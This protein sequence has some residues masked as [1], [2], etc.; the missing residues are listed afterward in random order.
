[1]LALD[2][3]MF[4][5]DEHPRTLSVVGGLYLL[6]SPPQRRRVLLALERAVEAFPRLA[7][8]AVV[9]P[10]RLVLPHW[11]DDPGFQLEDHLRERRLASPGSMR[12]LLDAVRPELAAP[13]EADRP[14]WD[15][16]LFTG[17]EDGRGAM[18][19]R[20]SHALTDG[21]GAMRLFEAL[22]AEDVA[23]ARR[24][25]HAAPATAPEPGEIQAQAIARLSSGAVAGAL[26]MLPGL[27]ASARAAVRDP[28]A[29]AG[30]V[31]SYLASVRRVLGPP[32]P[33]APTLAGR[34]FAR[35][36]A[37]LTVPLP[38][39]KQAARRLESSINDVYLA[40]IAGALRRYQLAVGAEPEDVPLAV[41]VNLR[42][43]DEEAAGNFI[44]ALS[45]ALPASDPSLERR[46]ETIREAMRTG[47]AEPALGAHS[48]F[49]PL[50]ARL[51]DVLLK[52]AVAQVWRA[53]VQASNVPGPAVRP[54]FAGC[55]VLAAYPFGPVPGVGAM[56][57]ML[58]V[59]DG[60]HVAVHFDPA[61]F[62]E[63]EVFIECLRE[64]FSEVLEAGR[65]P[66]AIEPPV[67]D[68]GPPRRPS[69][70]PR[71]SAGA[72]AGRSRATQRK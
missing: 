23:P 16:L 67:L 31:E 19:F 25:R 41:P 14:L 58:S 1:M 50:L 18:F 62:T 60:C 34:S 70:R 22:F 42:R 56:I 49:A 11:V 72:R 37:L 44:G 7:Q 10:L 39:L 63:P 46:L 71:K 36:C 40:S 43:G 28:A 17:L 26:R 47:R 54:S 12:N 66:C 59:G 32:C 9:P 4:R 5:G 8:R 57:A 6:D 2:A 61:A 13:L 64:G 30:S 3:L 55:R 52:R 29:A 48:M 51:P 45:L 20:M 15:A 35:R 27:I 69:P 21:L 68:H 53:D 65:Q 33:P 38:A 24:R